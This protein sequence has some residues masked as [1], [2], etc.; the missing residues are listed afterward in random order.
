MTPIIKITLEFI[1]SFRSS[2][3]YELKISERINDKLLSKTVT[4]SI[5]QFINKNF[6]DHIFQHMKDVFNSQIEKEFNR[7]IDDLSIWQ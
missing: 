6:N 2:D 4:Y 1:P 3:L 5:D 7:D